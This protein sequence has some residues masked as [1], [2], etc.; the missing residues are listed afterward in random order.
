MQY[1]GPTHRRDI[2]PKPEILQ[3]SHDE[4]DGAVAGGFWDSIPAVWYF[5]A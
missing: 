3:C 5:I 4:N 2:D 1:T